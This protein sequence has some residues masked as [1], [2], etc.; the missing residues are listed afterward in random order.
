MSSCV[1]VSYLF[2]V[3]EVAYGSSILPA[4]P[5]FRVDCVVFGVGLAFVGLAFVGICRD[6]GS[7][8]FFFPTRLWV[9]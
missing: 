4:A 2:D 6:L 7:R 9:C 8:S 3:D 1:V 5:R